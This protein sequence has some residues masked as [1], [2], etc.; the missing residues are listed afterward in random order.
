MI[1]ELISNKCPHCH[2]GLVF[3]NSNLFTYREDKINEEC[4]VCHRRFEKEP[5]FYMG[6]MY[7]SY[8]LGILECFLT[9]FLLS[10]KTPELNDWVIIS[11]TVTP[12]LLLAPFNFRMARLVWLYIFP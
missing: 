8:G 7:V 4:P 2:Q 9:Y 10:L 1:L 5:G 6:A 12:I 11:L 3:E